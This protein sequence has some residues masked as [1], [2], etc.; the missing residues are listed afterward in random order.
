MGILMADS[1]PTVL[2]VRNR[3]PTPS[4]K[5]GEAEL[6]ENPRGACDGELELREF[7]SGKRHTAREKVSFFAVLEGQFATFAATVLDISSNGALVYIHDEKFASR[8][9]C[10][11]LMKYGSRVMFQFEGCMQIALKGVVTVFA[12]V[13]R[14]ARDPHSDRILV[15]VRFADDLTDEE[16]GKLG[17]D[18]GPDRLCTE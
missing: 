15:G 18:L 3:A 10:A 7:F 8:S 11:D 16:S 2:Y 6:T 14:L 9:T 1:D 13:V 5:P 12:D 4:D 17:L